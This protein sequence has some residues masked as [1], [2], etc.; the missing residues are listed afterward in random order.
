LDGRWGSGNDHPGGQYLLDGFQAS[1]KYRRDR[2][3]AIGHAGGDLKMANVTEIAPG[4]FRISTFAPE[5]NM[6][7]NQFL[8]RDEEPLLWHTGL[9]AHF[10]SVR[11][12][13]ARLVKPEALR[14]IGFSHFEADE[15][16]SLAE[17]QRVAPR[18]TAFASLVAKV[19][20]VDDSAA[21]RPARGL[22]D[23]EV[24]ETGKYRFRFLQTPHLPHNWEAG[25]LFE[26]TQG[27]LFC[28]DLFHHNGDVPPLTTGDVLGPFRV[29]LLHDQQGPFAFYMPWTSQTEPTLKRLAALRPKTLAVMH[30]SSFSGDSAKALEDLIPMLRE[31]VNIPSV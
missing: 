19:V 3:I 18:A 28:S 9:K 17:W 8:I 23:G 30:G 6:Q 10:P 24:L 5:I 16:G 4:V 20:S 12:A 27:T 15:C 22:T 2:D 29:K 7:F 13:V 21:L 11:D 26:E 31:I 1:M 14:W 25:L